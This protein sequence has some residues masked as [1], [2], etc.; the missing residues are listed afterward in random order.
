MTAKLKLQPAPEQFDWLMATLAEANSCCNAISETAFREKTFKQ[1]A[2]HKLVYKACRGQ[3][4]LSSQMVIRAIGKV[5]DGY[6]VSRKKQRGFS[7]RGA[8]P[9]DARILSFNLAQQTASIWTVA[10]RQSIPFVGSDPALARLQ[11]ERGESDLCF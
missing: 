11:G 7:Q 8:F 1:F 10:G 2:L 6:K 3:F 5:A 9:Y 4:N